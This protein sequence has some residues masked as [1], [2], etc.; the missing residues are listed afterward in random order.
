MYEAI[1]LKDYRGYKKG[2]TVLLDDIQIPAMVVAKVI[3]IRAYHVRRNPRGNRFKIE[4]AVSREKL[5]LLKMKVDAYEKMEQDF[6][7]EQDG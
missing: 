6:G 1:F 4:L 2:E 7:G 5:Q 3:D